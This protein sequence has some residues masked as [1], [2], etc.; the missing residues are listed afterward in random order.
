MGSITFVN[1]NGESTS[2]DLEKTSPSEALRKG[3]QHL[4]NGLTNNQKTTLEELSNSEARLD[5]EENWR[6]GYDVSTEG[7]LGDYPED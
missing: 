6:A 2:F 1:C 7:A 3:G 5:R 4:D